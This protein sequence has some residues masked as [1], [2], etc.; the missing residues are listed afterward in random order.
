MRNS[1]T[2]LVKTHPIL[3]IQLFPHRAQP[4]FELSVQKARS[5]G[6]CRIARASSP[7]QTHKRSEPRRPGRNRGRVSVRPD[8]FILG[9]TQRNRLGGGLAHPVRAQV[10]ITSLILHTRRLYLSLV[11]SQVTWFPRDQATILSIQVWF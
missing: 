4:P 3:Y 7:A 1:R 11:L 8:G 9:A 10:A 5:S 6:V 2:L